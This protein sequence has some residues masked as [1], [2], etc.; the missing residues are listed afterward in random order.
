[1]PFLQNLEMGWIPAS[2]GMTK[3]F[4]T[5]YYAGMTSVFTQARKWKSTLHNFLSTTEYTESTKI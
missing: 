3:R 4:C 5:S 1:M 2:A